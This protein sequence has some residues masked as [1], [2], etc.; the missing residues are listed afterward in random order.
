MKLPV[1]VPDGFRIVAHRG[2]SGYA[3]ENTLAAFRLAA[4]MGISDVEADVRFSK[5]RKLVL[6][7]DP[8]MGRYGYPDLRVED[9][10]LDEL[11]TLDMGSWYSPFLYGG[12]RLMT[13]GSLLEKFGER[14]IYHLELKAP[15]DG[16]PREV[17]KTLKVRDHMRR[18]I[19]TSFSFDALTEVRELAADIRV[20]WLVKRNGLSEENVA[21]V[22]EAG[23]CQICPL[24][25]ETNQE[26]VAAA[27][28]SIAEVR[29][30]GVTGVPAMLQAIEAGCDGLTINWPDWLIHQGR[31]LQGDQSR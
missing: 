5:D 30:H 4:E 7:H 15:V 16:M 10:T 19:I 12:E 6:C 14:F 13:L 27:H 29:A 28:R 3:P 25:E 8:E 11:L 2:A 24:A 23:F 26:N 18:A 17:L 20:G 9:L 1:R 22:A 31:A 21:R